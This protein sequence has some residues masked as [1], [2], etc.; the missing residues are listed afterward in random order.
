MG[1]DAAWDIGLAHPDL[2]AGVIPITAESGRFCRLLS[3]ERPATCPS[4]SSAA[5][6]TAAAWPRTPATWTNISRGGYNTTVVEYLGRG[7]EHFSDEQLRLFDWM[8]R[9][10]RDFFPREFDCKTMRQ[11][12]NFFWWVGTGR[13]AAGHHGRSRR[14]AAPPRHAA[15]RSDRKNHRRQQPVDRRT[16]TAKLTV[17]LSPEMVDFKRPITI[18]WQRPQGDRHCSNLG[19]IW[20]SCLEDLRAR[21]DRQHPF[22]ANRVIHGSGDCTKGRSHGMS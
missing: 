19:P 22:W 20:K 9:F 17:W 13:D 8:G 11:W 18:V 15:R 3:G 10:H 1:G 21:G 14:L 6:W 7:H 12:D 16:K 4:T 2:W 5:S